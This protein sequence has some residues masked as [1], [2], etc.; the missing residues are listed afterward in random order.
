MQRRWENNINMDL[1]ETGCEV[2]ANRAGSCPIRGSDI[3]VS[4][5]FFSLVRYIMPTL[6]DMEHTVVRVHELVFFW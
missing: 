1:R 3:R 5:W 6:H 4:H 2:N